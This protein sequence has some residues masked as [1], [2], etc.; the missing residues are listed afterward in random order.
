MEDDNNK[1]MTTNNRLYQEKE[2]IQAW[3]DKEKS[4]DMA[5]LYVWCMVGVY[6]PMLQA[7]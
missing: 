2:D 3:R 7:L 4:G 5:L 6:L 1:E